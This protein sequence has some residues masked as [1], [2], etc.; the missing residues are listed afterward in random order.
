M[1]V[2]AGKQRRRAKNAVVT[3]LNVF[4]HPDAYERLMLH[5]VKARLTPGLFVESLIN[6]HCRAWKIQANGSRRAASVESDGLEDRHDDGADVS[7]ESV[8][9]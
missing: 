9:G 4:I 8:A 7:L 6:T 1:T 5:S 2:V 3:R